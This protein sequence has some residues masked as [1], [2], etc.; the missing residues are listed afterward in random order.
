MWLVKLSLKKSYKTKK[1]T[2]PSACRVLLTLTGSYLHRYFDSTVVYFS[3]FN[4]WERV[5]IE[6]G[7]ILIDVDKLPLKKNINLQCMCCKYIAS[8]IPLLMQR[9]LL[10]WVVNSWPKL[11]YP[12]Q[13][14]NDSPVNNSKKFKIVMLIRPRKMF[15]NFNFNFTIKW[16]KLWI[17]EFG[18]LKV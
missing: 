2:L 17:N 13:W 18:F 8:S 12:L 6:Y 16:R 7:L 1:K 10:R 14:Y 5:Y 11:I 9:C 15:L 3:Y 4:E